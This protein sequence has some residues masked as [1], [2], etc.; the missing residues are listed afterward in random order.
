MDRERA[1]SA[2]ASHQLRTPLTGLRLQLETAL[3]RPDTALRTAIGD[4]LTSTDR[5]QTTIDELLALARDTPGRWNP[6]TSNPSWTTSADGGTRSSP[7]TAGR[8]G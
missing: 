2:D 4:A 3:D 5:L 6:S 7:P 1:F 8:C